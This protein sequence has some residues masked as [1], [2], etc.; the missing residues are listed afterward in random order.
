V[1]IS[2]SSLKKS[3]IHGS[4]VDRINN[5]RN[6]TAV[7]SINRIKKTQNASYYPSANHLIS[8]DLYYDSLK[9]LKKEYKKFYHDEQMLERAIE[10]F[11]DN[12]EKL[13]D[14]MKQLVSKY[15]NAILSLESFDRSF[16]TN[17]VEKIK[18]LLIDFEDKLNSLGIYIVRDNELEINEEVFVKKIKDSKNAINFLFEPA[19]GLILK[20]FTA[21][22]SIKIP[23]KESLEKSYSE[24]DYAGILFD[25]KA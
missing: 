7:E 19:K 8:Y 4:Y 20:I 16:K 11:D 9:E 17:N 6:T 2:K 14:N 22:K 13:L 18:K 15:N 3:R 23:R 25:N 21:F 24:A 10:N 12:K 1:K 5:V